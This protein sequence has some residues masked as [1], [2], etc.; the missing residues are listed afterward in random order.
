M[1]LLPDSW[2]TIFALET[3]LLELVARGSVLY[4]AILVLMRFMPRRTGGELALM[5][6]V[7]VVLIANAAANALG[8][9]SAVPD[10]IVLIAT[11][12]FWDYLLNVL[13]YRFPLVERWVS[14]P[15]LE[16]IRNGKLLRRNMKQ[17]LLTEEELIEQLR[18]LGIEAIDDVKV[19]YVESEGKITAIPRTRRG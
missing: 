17:E 7:F 9:Y 14:P 18:Q 8:D 3:P 11:L 13:S 16:I 6:L 15:P 2:S 5:D 1:D 10:A 19:A 12:M 4:L